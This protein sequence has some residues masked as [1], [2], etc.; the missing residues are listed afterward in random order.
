MP[1]SAHVAPE[2]ACRGEQAQHDPDPTRSRRPSDA[3]ARHL[4]PAVRPAGD[5]AV[6][7]ARRGP[8][9]R[10]HHGAGGQAPPRRAR[11]LR[12]VGPAD[13]GRPAHRA[14]PPRRPDPDQ[15]RR[16]HAHGRAQPHRPHGPAGRV[17]PGRQRHPD[18]RGG[19]QPRRRGAR[20]H[21]RLQ[22]PADARQG[23][24]VRP[25]GRGVPRRAGRRLRLDR[26]G[27][28]RPGREPDVG[29]VGARV[30][31]ARGRGRPASRPRRWRAPTRT[32]C[33]ATP[34][35]CCT[36]RAGRRSVG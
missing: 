8:P 10:R 26:H 29:P 30:D 4:R 7:G 9:G 28:P 5:P 3:R 15:R 32:T 12:P 19:G 24:R 20:R 13:A 1:V 16:R 14:R 36:A 21:G 22:G 25:A 11:L 2:G 33:P 31:R 23:V 6:R 27:L 35:S 34:V 18:P 17:P